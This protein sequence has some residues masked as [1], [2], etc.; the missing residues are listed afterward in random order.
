[1]PGHQAH[2]AVTSG[3]SR[4]VPFAVLIEP[5]LRKRLDALDASAALVCTSDDLPALVG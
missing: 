4:V 2:P 1:M 3:A 5:D